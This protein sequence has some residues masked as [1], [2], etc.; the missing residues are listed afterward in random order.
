MLCPFCPLW[1]NLLL[2]NTLV[3]PIPTNL[4][5]SQ[6]LWYNQLLWLTTD[7][8]YLEQTLLVLNGI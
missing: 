5:I 2:A 6:F 7:L 4:G 1:Y 3:C 8:K